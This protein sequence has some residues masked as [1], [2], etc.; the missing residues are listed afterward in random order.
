ME[1]DA[2][3]VAAFDRL[4]V[5]RPQVQNTARESPIA[6]VRTPLYGR[7]PSADSASMIV[8]TSPSTM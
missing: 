8:L 1:G 6:L 3:A 7:R 4:G 5:V 2:G